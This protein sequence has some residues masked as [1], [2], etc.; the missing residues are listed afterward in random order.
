MTAASDTPKKSLFTVV[1]GI[2]RDEFVAV[3]WSFAYFFCVLSSYYII[4]PVREEM[5]VGS[6][7]NS[8]PYLFIGTFVTMI[9]ATSVFGWV[10]SRFPRRQFLPWVYLFFI[11]NMLIFWVVFAQLRGTGE[12]YIWLG[13]V[14]FVWV[15]VFNLFVVS[16]F[17][18]FMADIYTRK[19][20]RRLFGFIT[21]G[22]SIGALVGGLVTSML[23]TRIG[24]QNLIPI[25]A[26]VLVVAVFCIGR[27]KDWVHQEH[28][29]EI[30]RTVESEAPLG[31]TPLAGITH[32]LSS[33]YF[34]GI[35]LMSV[36]ASLLGTALYMFRAELIET[37]ILSP[38]ARTQFFSNMNVAQNAL[39]L[40]A[41]MF[42]VKQVV[43]RFGIGRS[44]S[45]FPVAS[46]I[47]FAILALEPTLMAVAVLDVVRR[48]LGFGF[49]KPSTDMLYSVVT[50]EEKYK[51]K[52][53]I[54][55]A[56]YRGGDVVGTWSIK[57]LSVLGMGMAAISV[58][59]LP[60]AVL[61]A[62]VALWLGRDYKRRAKGLAQ[63]GVQ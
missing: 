48:G 26:A 29:S 23:V 24:F 7:P 60:F 44:L 54:E 13:R 27:L 59:M 46:I 14:F 8:I 4:R 56:V 16:V 45:L 63:K 19:Q 61:S 15:S 31:G 21:S 37:A 1:F 40:I 5:A 25:A 57:L 32:L 20:G 58:V 51:T 17:W 36:V 22:G 12:D 11:A 10:A 18:S 52:N 33:N 35:A 9:F 47:G 38:D 2:E 39:A 53:A 34:L 3:G 28:E 30:D 55:T 43:T 50:P 42:L 62:V 49:A 41:Q 6:G